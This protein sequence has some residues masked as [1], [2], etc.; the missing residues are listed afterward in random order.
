MAKSAEFFEDRLKTLLKGAGRYT[1]SLDLTI[2]V[3]G[4]ALHRYDLA[5]EELDTAGSVVLSRQTS[6]GMSVSS[7]P[8][9]KIANEA[10]STIL[11]QFKAL[12]L[13]AEDLRDVTDV[14]PAQELADK[15]HDILAKPKKPMRPDKK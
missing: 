15:I 11:K 9:A 14:D 4:N 1:Q 2:W 7:H 12:G 3:L 6:Q 13:T 5:N 8:A 10:E